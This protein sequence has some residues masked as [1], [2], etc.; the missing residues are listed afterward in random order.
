MSDAI[1]VPGLVF[2]VVAAAAPLT[3]MA[4][5]APLTIGIGNGIGAPGAYALAGVVLLLFAVGYTAMSRFVQNA[6][7]FYA[8]IAQGLDKRLGLGAAF[9]ALWTYNTIQIG[10]YGLFGLFASTVIADRFGLS[11]SWQAWAFIGIALV[12]VLGVRRITLSAWVLGVVLIAEVAILSVMALGIVFAGGD[13][14]LSLVSFEPGNI[15]SGAPGVAFMFGFAAFIGFEATAIYGE[16][17]RDYRHTVSRATYI[18]VAFLGIFYAF[19]CWSI[20]NAY[21]TA[22]VAQTAAETPDTLFFD[23]TTR[24]VGSFATDL[25][26]ILIVSSIFAALLAFHNATNRYFYALGREGAL[27]RQLGITHSTYRSPWVAGVV[28]T[29][30]AGIV[31]GIFALTGA[32]PLL[33]LLSWLTGSG[34]VGILLLQALTSIAVLGYFRRRRDLDD[35]PWNTMVAPILGAIGLLAGE[36]L[37]LTNFDIL[38]GASTGVNLALTLPIPL[39]A[40]IGY[41]LAVRMRRTRP[42]R[43]E[44]IGTVRVADTSV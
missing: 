6:G 31:V 21:G 36:V 7:A 16:E 2:F 1:G 26:E 29:A 22:N 27:P 44:G 34:T 13:S 28:Q 39:L 3:V 11:L 18:A 23:A 25:M 14:G 41:L 33:D 8:Y 10:L 4:G 9:V 35:R 40:A 43:Y 5:A 17:S 42:E 24:Y 30:L 20:V 19:V 12:F 32:D 37:V 15:F 38:T